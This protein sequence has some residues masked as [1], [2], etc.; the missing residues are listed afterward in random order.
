MI[1]NDSNAQDGFKLV[2]QFESEQAAVAYASELQ[3]Y[4]D[5]L[6]MDV[7]VQIEA[8]LANLDDTEDKQYL[9]EALQA[10][11]KE[12]GLADDSRSS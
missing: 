1:I 5:S 11:Q 4:Y 2:S 9:K 6:N 7:K 12:K 3:K 8:N 10:F